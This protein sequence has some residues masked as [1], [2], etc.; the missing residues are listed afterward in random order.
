MFNKKTIYIGLFLIL[1]GVV[2]TASTTIKKQDAQVN[3]SEQAVLI[4]GTVVDSETQMALQGVKVEIADLNVSATTDKNG[5]FTF[6][7]LKAG[8]VYE[9]TIEHEGYEDYEKMVDTKTQ[10]PDKEIEVELEPEVK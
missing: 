5:E 8:E 6:K 3:V 7:D 2:S 1:F 9:L 4:E 10:T